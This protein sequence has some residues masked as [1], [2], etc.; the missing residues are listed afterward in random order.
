M[1]CEWAVEAVE[2]GLDQVCITKYSNKIERLVIDSPQTRD[3]AY[4]YCLIS[5]YCDQLYQ[6]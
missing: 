5:C 2:M 3:G 6:V 4:L 1:I